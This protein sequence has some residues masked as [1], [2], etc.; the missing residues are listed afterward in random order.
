MILVFHMFGAM[1]AYLRCRNAVF[2]IRTRD[3]LWLN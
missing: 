3:I 2:R 1:G